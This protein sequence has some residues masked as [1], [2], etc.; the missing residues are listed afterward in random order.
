MS[1]RRPTELRS[2]NVPLSIHRYTKPN[3]KNSI[4]EYWG[5][6]NIQP[7]FPP[8]EKLFKT[9]E[10]ERVTEYGISFHDEIIEVLNETQIKT[11]KGTTEIHKKVTMLLNPFKWMRGKYGQ[12]LDLPTSSEQASSYFKKIQNNNNA[13]YVGALIS[14]VLSESECI[15]FP[16]TYGVFVGTSTEHTIDIS[17]DYE[18]LSE[19]NWFTQNIGKTFDVKLSPEIQTCNDFKHTRSERI[20]LQLGES[21]DLEN[22]E[23]ISTI[24]TENVVMADMTNIFKDDRNHDESKSDSSSVSTSY[25]FDIHSCDCEDSEDEDE[26]IEENDEPFAWATFKNVPVQI[27]IMEKCEGTIFEL[28]MMNPDSEKHIAWITQ[29]MFALAFA[30]KLIGLTHNDLHAN[31]I[32]YIKT[33]KE[34]LYY[35]S[36]GTLYKV[37]TFGYIIKIIDF[38]RG[39]FS[40]KLTGMKEPKLFISDHFELHEEA[41]GQYNYGDSYN[42]KYPEIKPN[43]SFDLCRFA[44]S[45]FWDLF[46]EGPTHL[47]Y[48][49][50]LIFKLFMK[51][52]N[53]N[54][55]SILFSEKDERHDRFHGF[56]L[57]KAIARYCKDNAIPRKEILSVKTLYETFDV[58]KDKIL[59]ID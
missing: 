15:H 45:V 1:K 56:H 48:K 55:K 49:E 12:T 46:P 37:P 16:K 44:T 35:N 21:I 59:L 9:S 50:N 32:M 7:Y 8:I 43:A 20:S 39:I 24:Q 18:E 54:D 13:A 29:L 5:F 58:P 33:D 23:E 34:F 28:M 4:K 52:L 14:S 25:I 47:E 38:E 3:L 6:D 17:D 19:S 31:N 41:G 30:Q 26:E 57:Y 22:I 10:L 53:I 11:L 2:S 42:S 40:L 36:G 51:W 27:T